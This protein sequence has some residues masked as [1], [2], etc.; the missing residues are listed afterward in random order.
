MT[1]D[2]LSGSQ[3]CPAQYADA[4]RLRL[5]TFGLVTPELAKLIRASDRN[6]VTF[7]SYLYALS[8]IESSTGAANDSG[9]TDTGWT[10]WPLHE[11]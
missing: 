5:L 6:L 11:K 10:P 2:T 8:T 3:N 7:M 4:R 1:A 9:G